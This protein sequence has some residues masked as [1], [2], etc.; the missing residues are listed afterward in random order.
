MTAG[1]V[2]VVSACL[3]LCE[4]SKLSS[5]DVLTSFLKERSLDAFVRSV[6]RRDLSHNLP[7]WGLGAL[8]VCF[9]S[10]LDHCQ[11]DEDH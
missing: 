11:V 9:V 4:S 7:D 5:A 3:E 8:L 6:V 10:L 1:L 2:D